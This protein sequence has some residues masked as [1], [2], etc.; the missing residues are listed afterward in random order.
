MVSEADAMK[1]KLL[2]G[3]AMTALEKAFALLRPAAN[4]DA[5][6]KSPALPEKP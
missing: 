4:P 5:K 3:E 6:P 2:V 1:A